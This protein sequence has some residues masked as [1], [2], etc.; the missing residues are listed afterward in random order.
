MTIIQASDLLEAARNGASH[1][2][3]DSVGLS[4]QDT[5]QTNL[6]FSTRAVEKSVSDLICLPTASQP[7]IIDGLLLRANARASQLQIDLAIRGNVA[8]NYR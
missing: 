8:S 3:F 5:T 2:E 4:N 6:F 1:Y 7:Q